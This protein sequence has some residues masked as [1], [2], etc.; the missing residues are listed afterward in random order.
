MGGSTTCVSSQVC[1]QFHVESS[2]WPE[3]PA[4]LPA[5]SRLASSCCICNAAMNWC[6]RLTC[7]QT[8]R[9]GRIIKACMW[10]CE[11][12]RFCTLSKKGSQQYYVLTRASLLQSAVQ[13]WYLVLTQLLHTAGGTCPPNRSP[14]MAR[15]TWDCITACKVCARAM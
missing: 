15:R 14:T 5:L 4:R 13:P 12:S 7:V 11:P 9:R 10:L 8:R 1:C 2:G 6:C 3:L